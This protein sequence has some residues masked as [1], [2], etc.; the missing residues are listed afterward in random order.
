MIEKQRQ[1]EHIE[2]LLIWRHSAM[3]DETIYNHWLN[4]FQEA[5]RDVLDWETAQY[6][7]GKVIMHT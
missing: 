7:T 4:E 6:D 3:P 5:L 1:P 2:I